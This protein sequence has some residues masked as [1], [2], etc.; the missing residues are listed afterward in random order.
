M[1]QNLIGGIYGHALSKN[2]NGFR[3]TAGKNCRQLHISVLFNGTLNAP[4]KVAVAHDTDSNAHVVASSGEKFG[5]ILA[6]YCA[7]FHIFAI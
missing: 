3:C 7:D 1:V 2:G 5:Y 6:Y 4:A